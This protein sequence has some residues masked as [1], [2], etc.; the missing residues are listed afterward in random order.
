MESENPDFLGQQSSGSPRTHFGIQLIRNYII[1]ACQD[2]RKTRKKVTWQSWLLCLGIFWLKTQMCDFFCWDQHMCSSIFFLLTHFC[3]YLTLFCTFPLRVLP[4]KSFI[5]LITFRE[6]T[7]F[8]SHREYF[9]YFESCSLM[10]K[11]KI[12]LLPPKQKI[13]QITYWGDR[14]FLS[15]PNH[16]LMG[17]LNTRRYYFAI[18]MCTNPKDFWHI[19]HEFTDR[20]PFA[21][22][23]TNW[24]TKILMSSEIDYA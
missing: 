11:E 18:K 19:H 4:N 16:I 12:S 6:H 21:N 2:N 1:S 8:V 10:G 15:F 20:V 5:F 3:V 24:L 9:G 14:T 13:L 22:Y 17:W 23:W 7:F